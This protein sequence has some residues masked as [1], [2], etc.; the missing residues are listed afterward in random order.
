M[1]T[2]EKKRNSV[3]KH[4]DINKDLQEDEAKNIKL[5]R[6]KIVEDGKGYSCRL[7]TFASGMRIAAKTHAVECGK[8]QQTRRKKSKNFNCTECTQ[9]FMNKM[10]L[11]KHFKNNHVTSSYLCTTCGKR[12]S[13]RG[14]FMK[15]LRIH[16]SSYTPG[17]KCIFCSFAARDNWNLDKHMLSHFK[18]SDCKS[19]NSPLSSFSK[20][21]VEVSLTEFQVGNVSSILYEMTI[22]KKDDQDMG[23]ANIPADWKHTVDDIADSFNQLGLED[24]D[25]SDWLEMSSILG[26]HPFASF[27]SWVGYKNDGDKEVFQVCIQEQVDQQSYK[28]GNEESVFIENLVND[29]SN[30]VCV[31]K[32]AASKDS[33]DGDGL[34][35]CKAIVLEVAG[36]V[37]SDGSDDLSNVVPDEKLDA[38]EVSVDGL[39]ICQAIVL[40]LAGKAVGKPKFTCDI[41]DRIFKDSAHMKEHKERMHMEPTPCMIC[42]VMFPDKHS[43]SSHQKTC[44]RRCPYDHCSFQSRHKHTFLKHLRGHE[45]LLRRFSSI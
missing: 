32:L 38:P 3:L 42:N 14:S 11:D 34:Q 24:S 15:H 40:E 36:V 12:S 39:Q 29:L 21:K 31:E 27:M 37:V 43:A 25:W 5:F 22:H 16:D 23:P 2:I 18:D 41:C 35:I 9:N 6:E 28:T 17:F 13:S 45:R 10:C 30:V 20:M 1:L 4:R 8:K 7:C 44:S 26:L 19:I 33:V